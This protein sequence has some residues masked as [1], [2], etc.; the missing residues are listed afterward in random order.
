MK[1][2]KEVFGSACVCG[3][4]DPQ[5]CYGPYVGTVVF[6][7]GAEASFSTSG[8]DETIGLIPGQYA[9]V[10]NGVV[11]LTT[12]KV[13]KEWD[14]NVFLE[15]SNGEYAE[16]TA[17]GVKGRLTENSLRLLTDVANDLDWTNP[18]TPWQ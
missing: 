2:I 16:L 14:G 11:V 7:D 17:L 9:L 18:M 8:P 4:Y 3:S 15:F 12:T 13:E 5:N 10:E 1:K 6:T